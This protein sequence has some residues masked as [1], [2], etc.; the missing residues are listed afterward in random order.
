MAR[1]VTQRKVRLE[2]LAPQVDEFLEHEVVTIDGITEPIEFE[3]RVYRFSYTSRRPEG[4]ALTLVFREHL[5]HGSEKRTVELLFADGSTRR[6]QDFV[7]ARSGDVFE[8][9]EV[10]G[11]RFKYDGPFYYGPYRAE[12]FREIDPPSNPEGRQH[13]ERG[14]M[15]F[16]RSTL[17][18]VVRP[19]ERRYPCLRAGYRSGSTRN[20]ICGSST[21]AKA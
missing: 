3:G 7:L 8:P 16:G 14:S 10:G 17:R 11:H 19:I 21:T 5:P 20:T 9:I 2:S 15:R 6:I 12:G 13:R 18:A 1:E 4:E